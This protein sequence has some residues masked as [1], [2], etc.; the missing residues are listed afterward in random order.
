MARKFT[1]IYESIVNEDLSLIFEGLV[2]ENTSFASNKDYAIFT[3]LQP[4]LSNN[5]ANQKNSESVDVVL[6]NDPNSDNETASYVRS[7]MKWA[8]T[9]GSYRD[10]ALAALK[11]IKGTM[12]DVDTA[13]KIGDRLQGVEGG[14]IEP[15]ISVLKGTVPGGMKTARASGVTR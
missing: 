13:K 10:A 8:R 2:I 4:L 3:A 12:P 5:P 11:Y 7:L 1:E 15:G 9:T 14:K 6:G